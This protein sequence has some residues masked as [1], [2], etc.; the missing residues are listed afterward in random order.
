MAE[1]RFEVRLT[2]GAEDDLEAIHAWMTE[3]RSS[4]EA[5]LLLDKFLDAVATLERF[6][7][8]GSVPAEL[9]AL[10]IAEYRQ[11]LLTPYRLIYRIIGATVFIMVIADGR[12]DMQTLLE[13]RLLRE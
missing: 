1:A 9:D 8:R 3:N 6:P 12:R 13:F 4:E 2:E 5:N 11:I 10:G 7:L